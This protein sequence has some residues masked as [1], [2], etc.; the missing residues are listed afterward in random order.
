MSHHLRAVHLR[1]RAQRLRDLAVRIE[2]SPVHDLERLAGDDTWFGPRPELCRTMLR[3]NLHQLHRAA[4]DLRWQ[5]WLLEQEA[6]QHD[7]HAVLE[8]SRGG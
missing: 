3:S 7:A 5:A 6:R 1:D 2:S 8:A 4:D